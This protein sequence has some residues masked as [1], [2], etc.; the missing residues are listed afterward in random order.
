MEARASRTLSS[1]SYTGKGIHAHEFGRPSP[2]PPAPPASPL[3]QTATPGSRKA[4]VK[5]K[6]RVEPESGVREVGGFCGL[7]RGLCQSP[8]AS[9]EF[10]LWGSEEL[11][12]RGPEQGY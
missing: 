10:S 6:A 8:L 1:L 5:E 11:A 12:G 7:E 2:S 4:G 9:M 3:S